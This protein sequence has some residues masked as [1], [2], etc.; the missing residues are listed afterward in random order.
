MITVGERE[1][2]PIFICLIGAVELKDGLCLEAFHKA[3]QHLGRHVAALAPR[4][5]KVRS[6]FESIC[7]RHVEKRD[8]NTLQADLHTLVQGNLVL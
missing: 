2:K 7:D 6:I 8:N 4:I 3:G 5:E 1:N